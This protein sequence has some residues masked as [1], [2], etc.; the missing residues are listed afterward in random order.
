MY[1][2]PQLV[3]QDLLDLFAT[4]KRLV[5]YF[6]IPL[7]HISDDLLRSMNRRPLSAGIRKL[8]ARIRKSVPYA[9]VRTTF[10]VGYPGETS[11]HFNELLDFVEESKFERLGVFP[12]SPEQGTKAFSLAKRPSNAVAN[13]RCEEIMSLQREISASRCASLVGTTL[14][15]IIDGRSD[16]DL[17][18]PDTRKTQGTM[19][20]G[21]TVWDAPEVDGTVHIP[22]GGAQI[23]SI[24]PV[25]I[26]SATDYDLTATVATKR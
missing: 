25:T 3:S 22:D 6:D 14:D 5:P 12:Y 26:V 16:D 13:R 24:V 17:I 9:A 19:L 7:Q 2:H 11:R 1:L 10:I 23:G 15:V 20:T 21:R 4:E 8:V 18:S